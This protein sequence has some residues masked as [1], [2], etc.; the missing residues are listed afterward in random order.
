MPRELS[1]IELFSAPRLVRPRGFLFWH[2]PIVGRGM[3]GE[4]FCEDIM[5]PCRAVLRS[6]NRKVRLQGSRSRDT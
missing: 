2:S 6:S 5:P 3:L 4:L 1:A